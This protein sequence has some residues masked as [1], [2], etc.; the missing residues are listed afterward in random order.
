MSARTTSPSITQ[1]CERTRQLTATARA[2]S[3]EASV[4]RE[5][6]IR[7]LR[8][9]AQRCGAARAASPGHRQIV[10]R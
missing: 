9:A 7:E 6:A 5:R 4:K 8:F 10:I 2:Q 1:L 3:V